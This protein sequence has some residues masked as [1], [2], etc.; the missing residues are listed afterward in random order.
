MGRTVGLFRYAHRNLG[1]DLNG[2]HLIAFGTIDI[3]LFYLSNLV[4]AAVAFSLLIW[5]TEFRS[6][7]TP[8]TNIC[9]VGFSVI[10]ATLMN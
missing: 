2:H 1:V 10:L 8:C 9:L 7:A 3:F 6:L 5:I 4:V